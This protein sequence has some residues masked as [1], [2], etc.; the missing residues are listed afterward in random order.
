MTNATLRRSILPLSA[1]LLLGAL[2]SGL[3]LRPESAT[4]QNASLL[5]PQ[6]TSK[7]QMRRFR[8]NADRVVSEKGF[9]QIIPFE[10]MPVFIAI[11]EKKIAVVEIAENEVR[12]LRSIDKPKEFKEV[13]LL[14]DGRSFL[15]RTPKTVAVFTV[16]Q[17]FVQPSIR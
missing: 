3:A 1:A 2:I 15:V 17:V 5:A 7:L 13:I 9:E 10:N 6:P 16:D 8:N 12:I 4:A 14:G 11:D